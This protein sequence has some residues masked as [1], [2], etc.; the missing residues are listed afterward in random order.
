MTRITNKTAERIVV[1]TAAGLVCFE[2]AQPVYLGDR[3]ARYLAGTAGL[4]IER[5]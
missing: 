4:E 1:N 3:W 2:P 5:D